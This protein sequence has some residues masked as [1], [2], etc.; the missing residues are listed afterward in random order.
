MKAKSRL[1]EGEWTLNTD[2]ILYFLTIAEE[3]S[4]SAAAKKH[5]ISQTAISLQMSALEKELGCPL[6][7]RLKTG[8]ELTW[9]G[10]RLLPM[11][12]Q[13]M[14][15][16]QMLL[17]NMALLREGER[18]LRVAYTGPVEKAL[19]ESAF[20]HL[21]RAHMQV[22]LF[23]IQFPLSE[24]AGALASGACDLA[25]S[26][27]SEL[28]AEGI[29]TEI[30]A[31]YQTKAAVSVANP[32]SK[33]SLVTIT[34]LREYPLILLSQDASGSASGQIRK[35]AVSVGFPEE[36]ILEAGSIDAQMLMVSLNQGVS[37]FPD[38]PSI[39]DPGI[40]MVPIRDYDHQHEVAAAYR[41]KTRLIASVI[42]ALHEVNP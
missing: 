39:C 33:A 27:P 12:R 32:L 31:N 23:P 7:V 10:K 38:C 41:R 9:Q 14:K 36:M 6:F 1:Q 24:A 21:H 40:V 4:F 29:C 20:L 2:R 5:F 3:G 16:Q 15:S 8:A 22:S 30:I 18:E 34:Q 42:D 13:L 25:L 11:A 26:I 35:W 37:L 28:N 17:D 19:M